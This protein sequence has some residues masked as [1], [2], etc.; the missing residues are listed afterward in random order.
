MRMRSPNS[1]PWLNGDVGS[2]AITA[3]FLFC[4]DND[5]KIELS[6]ELLP[7]PGGPVMPIMG[8]FLNDR[9]LRIF[10]PSSALFSINEI[11]RASA[12]LSPDLIDSINEE[13]SKQ[14]IML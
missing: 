9:F 8:I 2:T 13:F 14:K 12:F 5:F 1:E 6:S 11:A 10:T 7:A 3:T 4:S